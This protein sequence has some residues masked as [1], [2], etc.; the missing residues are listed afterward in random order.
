[1]AHRPTDFSSRP[2]NRRGTTT[3]EKGLLALATIISA[4]LILVFGVDLLTGWPFD[5]YSLS[6]DITCLIS[7]AVLAYLIRHAYRELR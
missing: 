5:R 4:V 7:G 6:M 1:M 3:V 2:A